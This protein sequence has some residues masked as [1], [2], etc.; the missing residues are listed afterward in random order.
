MIRRGLNN[1]IFFAIV[2]LF[3][4]LTFSGCG[5]GSIS[6]S[7]ALAPGGVSTVP[8]TTD[9]RYSWSTSFENSEGYQLASIDGQNGWQI[10]ENTPERVGSAVVSNERAG[11]GL[12]SLKINY[13]VSFTGTWA[14]NLISILAPE[15]VPDVPLNGVVI[16]MKV[17]RDPASIEYP[18]SS[19]AK[20]SSIKCNQFFLFASPNR[21]MD[22]GETEND[23]KLHALLTNAV[24]RT[25]N[26]AGWKEIT[27]RFVE[28]VIYDN[29]KS[30]SRVVWYD[31]KRVAM[32]PINNTTRLFR[33]FGVGYQS[34]FP[35]ADANIG[36]P[37]FIDDIWINWEPATAVK[38]N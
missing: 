18:Q 17:W 10:L 15:V 20:Y 5:G 26:D 9:T 35:H 2:A 1:R 6:D 16:R 31:G 19:G 28:I 34:G 25:T 3:G 33:S 29:F 4:A 7:N 32:V 22:F 12:N 27:G 30:K 13:P 21:Y 37:I 36:T 38:T 24:P 11:T 8:P 14:E 23:E